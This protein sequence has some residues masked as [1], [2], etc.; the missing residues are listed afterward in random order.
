MTKQELTYDD[1]IQIGRQSLAPDE[2]WIIMHPDGQVL[3]D[4]A[5]KDVTQPCRIICNALNADWDDLTEQGYHLTKAY[6]TAGQ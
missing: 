3:A 6:I 1:I 2:Y 4:T 5:S